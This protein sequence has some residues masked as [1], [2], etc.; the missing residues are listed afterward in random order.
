MERTL[1]IIKPDAVIRGLIGRVLTYFE[2]KDLRIVNLKM[3]HLSREEAQGF[4]YVHRERL[5]Y[6]SLT[7]FMSSAPAVVAVLEG[8]GAI[9]RVREIMGAT[10]PEEAKPG[11]IR[12]ELG[13][14]VERNTVHGSDSPES[15]AY[16]IPFFFSQLDLLS[17]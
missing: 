2:G 12:K 6:E 14:N 5:F 15:A 17:H 7:A 16:E 9:S 13:E 8:D 11:T 10:N 3:V 1:I 4:Y